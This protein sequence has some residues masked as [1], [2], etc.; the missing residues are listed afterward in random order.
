MNTLTP[1]KIAATGYSLL[2]PPHR[3]YLRKVDATTYVYNGQTIFF[4]P[5][6]ADGGYDNQNEPRQLDELSELYRDRF[7]NPPTLIELGEILTAL[8]PPQLDAC[9][10]SLAVELASLATRFFSSTE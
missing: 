10:E 5:T 4:S 8:R 7:N 1:T 9:F 2:T 6:R 3:E